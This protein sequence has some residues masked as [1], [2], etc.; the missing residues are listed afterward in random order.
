MSDGE[1]LKATK[2][3]SKIFVTV[4]IIIIIVIVTVI[5]NIKSSV[6]M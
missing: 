5:N 1:N 6:V 4:I 3:N 2:K